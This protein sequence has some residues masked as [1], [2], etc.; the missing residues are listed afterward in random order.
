METC[1]C[2]VDPHTFSISQ[3]RGNFSNFGFVFAE[4]YVK[5]EKFSLSENSNN[6]FAKNI[7]VPT[8]FPSWEPTSRPMGK[9]SGT[10]CPV[11]SVLVFSWRP[12]LSSCPRLHCPAYQYK[13]VE[14]SST[15][16]WQKKVTN[17]STPPTQNPQTNCYIHKRCQISVFKKASPF[18]VIPWPATIPSFSWCFNGLGYN[19]HG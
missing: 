6:I 9:Y 18:C 1:S 19:H 3:F 2:R 14:E 8:L 4:R 16:K 11:R 15:R 12:L 17:R 13:T 5:N 10:V 7:L